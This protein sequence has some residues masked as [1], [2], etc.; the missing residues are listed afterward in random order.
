MNKSDLFSEYILARIASGEYTLG[1]KL[2]SIRRLAMKFNLSYSSAQRRITGLIEDGILESS[3]GRGLYVAKTH[4]VHNLYSGNRIIAFITPS[5]QDDATSITYV[6]LLAFQKHAAEAG[7]HVDLRPLRFFQLQ[8]EIFSSITA[9]YCGAAMFKEYDAG[10]AFF[11]GRTPAVATL[12]TRSF[13][14]QL[15]LVNIDPASAADQAVAY[16]QHRKVSRVTVCSSLKPVYRERSERFRDA[17]EQQ[18]GSCKI[19]YSEV[20]GDKFAAGRGYLFCSDTWL[21]SHHL[22]YR[23]ATGRDLHG[24]FAILGVDGKHRLNPE[25]PPFPSIVADW[26]EIGRIMFEELKRLIDNPK[27]A[28]RNIT[29]A[30]RLAASPEANFTPQPVDFIN[31]AAA[32]QTPP[33]FESACAAAKP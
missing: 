17:W 28:R 7:F 10:M 5:S 24:D 32:R 15:S 23:K 3:R 31:R 29:V 20:S 6:A 4:I 14:G 1:T 27:E 11:P 8:P 16:F 22:A 21:H 26:S 25:W 19:D 12:M 2:P 18:G 13:G 33:I 30:G 9:G